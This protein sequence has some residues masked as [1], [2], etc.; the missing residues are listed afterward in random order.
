MPLNHVPGYT[1]HRP[2]RA[3]PACGPG[4]GSTSQSAVKSRIH[5]IARCCQRRATGLRGVRCERR[6]QR[7]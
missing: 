4:L 3:S 6:G 1:S 7:S 5:T 2:K